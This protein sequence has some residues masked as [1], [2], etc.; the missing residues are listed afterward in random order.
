M[1]SINQIKILTTEELTKLYTLNNSEFVN[2]RTLHKY[3]IFFSGCFKMVFKIKWKCFFNLE[4]LEALYYASWTL[5]P[6]FLIL[7][8][9]KSQKQIHVPSR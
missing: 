4:N 5:M 1:I 9:S 2:S 6:I 8:V 3:L 7:Q